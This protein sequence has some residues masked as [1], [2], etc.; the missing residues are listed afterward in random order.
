MSRYSKKDVEHAVSVL[1]ER[2]GVT[3]KLEAWSPG[4]HHGTRYRVY[5]QGDTQG[6]LGRRLFAECG[7][8]A[9]TEGIWNM[10]YGIQYYKQFNKPPTTDATAQLKDIET[11]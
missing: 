4:D 3:L 7:A 5:T 9:A 6:S 1:A 2:L 10:I 8:K 11:Q